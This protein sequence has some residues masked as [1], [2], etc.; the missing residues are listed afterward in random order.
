[1]VICE[2]IHSLGENKYSSCRIG[3]YLAFCL[4]EYFYMNISKNLSKYLKSEGITLNEFSK[5]IS[6]SASTIHG[7]LNGIPP[8]NL[9]DVKKVADYF[10]VSLDEL[11]FEEVK[12]SQETNI[13]LKIGDDTYKIV[14]KKV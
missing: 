3:V 13:T 6:I 8:K 5:R 1:M 14:L 12:L 2:S 10:N 7:W 11:C 4:N 9:K